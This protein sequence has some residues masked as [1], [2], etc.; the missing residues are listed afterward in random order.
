M[1][2]KV[3]P[4]VSFDSACRCGC[5]AEF[6]Y[7]PTH[8]TRRLLFLL[9][10]LALTAGPTFYIA[11]VSRVLAFSLSFSVLPNFSS[12]SV[13][14]CCSEPCPSVGCLV[15]RVLYPYSCLPVRVADKSPGVARGFPIRMLILEARLEHSM[16]PTLQP[17]ELI[18]VPSPHLSSRQSTRTLARR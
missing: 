2:A 12:L 3:R 6:S 4:S 18:T 10:A 16:L 1:Q 14:P 9:V 11:V 15:T 8:L 7:V 17:C 13:R 5:I